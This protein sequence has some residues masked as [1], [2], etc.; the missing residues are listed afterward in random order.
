MANDDAFLQAIIEQPDDDSLRLIYADWLEEHDDPRGEFIRIQCALDRMPESDSRYPALNDRYSELLRHYEATW[1][2][3]LDTALHSCIRFGRGLPEYVDLP[4]VDFMRNAHILSRLGPIRHVCL[5]QVRDYAESLALCPFLDRIESL[6][7]RFNELL[8]TD[9][10]PLAELLRPVEKGLRRLTELSMAGNPIGPE[11]VRLLTHSME[12]N[13][14]RCLDLVDAELGAAGAEILVN[15]GGFA[16]LSELHVDCNA[17]RDPG[18]VFLSR[19]EKAGVPSVRAESPLRVLSLIDNEITPVGIRLLA[20][21]PR[22]GGLADLR[23]GHN[24]LGNSGVEALASGHILTNLTSLDLSATRMSA[25]GARA[26]AAHGRFPRLERLDLAHNQIGTAGAIALARSTNLS[27][28]K[29]L[30]LSGNEIGDDGA[31]ALA[32]SKHLTELA[33]LNLTANGIKAFGLKDLL[34][35]LDKL[36]TLD[37]SGNNLGNLAAEVLALSPRLSQIQNLSLHN[38]HIDDDGAKALAASKY[39]GSLRTLD[40]SQNHI[41]D[42]AMALLHAA[43][44]NYG[45]VLTSA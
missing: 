11:G 36:H 6:D 33:S 23:L 14:L 28:L 16:H 9:L 45:F 32:A 41:S 1:L 39:L 17:L 27:R 43:S 24:P 42:E 10:K 40:L 20:Q 15:W 22:F 18:V 29:W 25:S 21:S 4:L 26:L 13:N 19:W 5:S 2:E 3:P 35:A 8:A 30:D 12:G 7:L 34:V 44:L 37:I 38:N 31:K